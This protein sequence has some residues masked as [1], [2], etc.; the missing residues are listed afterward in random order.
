[1]MRSPIANT[2]S[3]FHLLLCIRNIHYA[4]WC[5]QVKPSNNPEG[6][7]TINFKYCPAYGKKY[8]SCIQEPRVYNMA[9]QCSLGQ[10]IKSGPLV[11]LVY[12]SFPY[13]SGPLVS[14]CATPAGTHTTGAVARRYYATCGGSQ[15]W[16]LVVDRANPFLKRSTPDN[17]RTKK[18]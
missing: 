5:R 7:S 12:C 1:M 4:P 13:N 6:Y 18:N 2:G 9:P 8:N 10:I 11:S 16:T 3:V 15:C 14:L 17:L